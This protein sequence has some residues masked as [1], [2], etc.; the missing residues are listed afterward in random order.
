MAK[1]SN[2]EDFFIGLE[3]EISKVKA[4]TSYSTNLHDLRRKLREVYKLHD[5]YLRDMIQAH[6]AQVPIPAAQVPIPAAQVPIST[7]VKPYT[8]FTSSSHTY[9]STRSNGNVYAKAH[10]VINDNGTKYRVDK[11]YD[12]VSGKTWIKSNIPQTKKLE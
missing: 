7:K 11:F 9:S 1:Y 3:T 6:V 8:Y 12:G 10:H 5:S 2:P 4:N